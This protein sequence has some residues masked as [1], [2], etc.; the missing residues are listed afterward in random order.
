MAYKDET[1][2]PKKRKV[3]PKVNYQMKVNQIKFLH[4]EEPEVAL[5]AISD[6]FKRKGI[7]FLS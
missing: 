3:P 5:D 4:K 2:I 6:I 7:L 1:E